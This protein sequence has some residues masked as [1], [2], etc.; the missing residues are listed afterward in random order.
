MI[1]NKTKLARRGSDSRRARQRGVVLLFSLI[2]LAI[3]LIVA[4]A[5]VRSFNN[6][7][8][9]AGNIGFKRD[10]QNQS[11]VAVATVLPLFRAGGALATPAQRANN[12]AARNYSASILPTNAEGIPD[13]LNSS[14]FSSSWTAGDLAGGTGVTVRYVI[15]RLCA[16]SGDETTIGASANC[17]L[18]DYAVP[19]GSGLDN[20]RSADKTVNGSAGA[21]P[22]GVLYRVSIKVLGPRN[23][24]SFFQSTFTAPSS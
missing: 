19:S 23:T 9:T 14:T 10:L 11:E 24:Q 15:D 4:V 13:V 5:L 12:A 21:A 3:M 20:L 2:A 8:F 16:I 18:A 22:Q 17:R 7:L 1:M 6:S